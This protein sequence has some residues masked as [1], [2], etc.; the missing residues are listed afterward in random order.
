MTARTVR[1]P[2]S[3]LGAALLAS[4]TLVVPAAAQDSRSAALAKELAALL[5][6]KKLDSIATRAPDAADRFVA[7]LFFPGQLLV[8]SARYQS[9]PLLNERIARHEY[10]DVYVDLN[11]AS[12]PESRV[13]FS[14]L[15]ADGF[16]PTRVANEPF[17]THDADGKAIRFDGNWREDKMSEQEYMKAFAQAD[18][19]YTAAL[20]LL[21]SAL[22]K[23]STR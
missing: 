16:R 4:T 7:A 19:S 5:Q 2:A 23:P 1:A 8:V 6:E 15:G 20:E 13:L 21:V 10:R 18:E 9:P 3:L 22:K 14:D 11:A 17:D 12:M